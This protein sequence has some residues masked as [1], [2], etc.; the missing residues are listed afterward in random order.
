MND[1]AYFIPVAGVLALVY[2]FIRAKLV[3]REDA[4]TDKMKEIAKHIRDGAMAFLARE[5]RVLGIFVVSVAVLLVAINWGQEKSHPM[6]AVSF[7]F[8]AVCSGLAGYIGMRVATAANVRTTAAARKSIGQAL[9]VAFSGGSVM[10]MVVA[11][12][13]VLGL[14]SL[15]LIYRSVFDWTAYSI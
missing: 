13:A 14:G 4:G 3:M 12:L 2:A 11:G 15:F 10:G 6:I 8:G 5:Y 9:Q 1:L 7:V